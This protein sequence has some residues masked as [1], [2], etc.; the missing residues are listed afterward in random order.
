MLKRCSKS[1]IQNQADVLY[2]GASQ[3]LEDR[4]EV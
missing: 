1:D 3:I 2:D 4:D